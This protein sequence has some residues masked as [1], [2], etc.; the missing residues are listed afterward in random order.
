MIEHIENSKLVEAMLKNFF[1]GYINTNDPFERIQIYK[2]K[3]QI[4]GLISYSV[5][6]E[7]AEIN[8][9]YVVD[10]HRRKHIGSKLLTAAIEEIKQAN[11]NS[12]SLEVDEKNTSAINLY[13][14]Y[15]FQI[16]AIRPFYYGK[17]NGYLLIKEVK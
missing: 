15:D 3:G 8:Y 16:K 4:I 13:Q 11:C 6:Y 2:E 7:R 1:P 5:I 10:N 14:K 17:N 9:I 12:I